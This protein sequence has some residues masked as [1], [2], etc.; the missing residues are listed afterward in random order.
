MFIEIKHGV[1]MIKDMSGKKIGKW[2]CVSKADRPSHSNEGGAWWNAVCECGYKSILNGAR[3]RAGRG[4]NTCKACNGYIDRRDASG[5][6]NGAYKTW[7]AMRSRCLVKSDTSYEYYGGRGITICDRWRDSF[8][9]FYK[10]MGDR[11]RG[12]TIERIDVNKGY[13]PENCEWIDSRLQGKNTRL[14]VLTD[15]QVLSL[16]NAYKVGVTQHDLSILTGASRSHIS[17]ITRGHSRVDAY[18]KK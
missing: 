1:R 6:L 12:F 16:I 5:K 15:E 13:S 4:Q 3:L 8:K 17:N 9:A 2:L 10:D 18:T 7:K 11:P 14:K